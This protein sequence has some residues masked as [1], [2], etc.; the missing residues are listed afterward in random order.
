MAN[1]TPLF[2]VIGALM[3]AYPDAAT[4]VLAG[5]LLLKWLLSQR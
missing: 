1:Q 2:F 3:L 4:A 5:V